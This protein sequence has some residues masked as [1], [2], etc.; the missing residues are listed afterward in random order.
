MPPAYED[1]GYADDDAA[2]FYGP[3][4]EGNDYSAYNQ[5]SEQWSFANLEANDE[6]DVD[7]DDTFGSDAPNLG[8]DERD[9]LLEDFG[10]NLHDENLNGSF[11]PGTP[12]EEDA[13]PPLLGGESGDGEVAKI[14][15][16]DVPDLI[17]VHV[18][19]D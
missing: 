1:E 2:G 11:R 4:N 12:L 5:L 7:G 6:R 14:V 17:G 16:D 8:E 15:L 13:V 19:S 3:F 10:D 9:R 18:N